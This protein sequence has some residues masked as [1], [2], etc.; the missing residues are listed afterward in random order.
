VVNFG[1]NFGEDTIQTLVVTPPH[2]GANVGV[3]I[4][5][6]ISDIPCYGGGSGVGENA[7]GE[8]GK[9]G[10]SEAT[11]CKWIKSVGKRE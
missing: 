6:D 9:N 2:V 11:H 7:E 1:D 10:E 5:I 4:D 8:E 3:G